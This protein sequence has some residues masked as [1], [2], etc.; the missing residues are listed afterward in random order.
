[1][2]IVLGVYIGTIV[3]LNIP[4]IQRFMSV[5]AS[6]ELS[7]V[8]NTEVAIGKIDIGLLN[9]I[10]IDDVLLN[11]QKGNE[12]L[13]IPRLSAKFDFIP[14]FKGKISI[15]NVQLFGLNMNLRQETPDSPP[16]FQFVLDAFTSK[17]TVKRESSLDIRINSVLIRRGKVTYHLLSEPET[18]GKFNSRHLQFQNIIGNLSLKALTK[19][20]LN[21]GIKRLSVDEAASGFSL[22]KM[23]LKLVANKKRMS[24]DNFAI[25]LP[26]SSLRMDTIHLM[27]A[28]VK[29]AEQF[30]KQAHCSFRILPSQITPKDI[31]PFIPAL[32][33]FKEPVT[34]NMEVNGTVDQF[35]CP[36]LEITAEGRQFRLLGEVSVQDLSHPK[37]AYIFGK[38]SE[39]SASS[40]G[41]GFLVRN[42]SDNYNGVPPLLELKMYLPL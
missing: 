14:F 39:L 27:Y 35:S 41:V 6:K 17:D 20:S 16:N 3:L 30:V 4:G 11:D 7:K 26:E 15:S 25:E 10:I 9:R 22:K 42:L 32:S 40:R 18:P 19:D 29:T 31:S 8:L 33:H 23:S 28:G 1:M 21:V 2:G 5:L 24:I 12:L 36:H 34:L 13:K 38:L 37:D